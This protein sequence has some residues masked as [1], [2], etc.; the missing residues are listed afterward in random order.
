VT[1]DADWVSSGARSV[2]K[3]PWY[4]VE[5]R[6]ILVSACQLENLLFPAILRTESGL[7][8]LLAMQKVEGSNPFSRSREGLHLR[9]SCVRS[10]LVR[11]RRAGP[12][13]DPWPTDRTFDSNE[14]PVCR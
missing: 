8:V 9:S 11:L 2:P 5:S 4:P 1:L 13:P 6:G 7:Q 12:K 10:R 14:T 3:P